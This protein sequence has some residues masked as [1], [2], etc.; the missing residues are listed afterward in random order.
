MIKM[1][2]LTKEKRQ[3]EVSTA[4]SQ[5]ERAIHATRDVKFL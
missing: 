2:A 1:H 5:Q 3:E 4:F